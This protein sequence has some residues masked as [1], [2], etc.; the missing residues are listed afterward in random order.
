MVILLSDLPSFFHNKKETWIEYNVCEN[1][2]FCNLIMSSKNT[3][4]LEFKQYQKCDK[5]QYIIYV[6]IYLECIIQ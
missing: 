6:Y 1:K 4:I 3:K 2:D 5:A